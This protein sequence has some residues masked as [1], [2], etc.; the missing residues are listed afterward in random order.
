MSL[1]PPPPGSSS[2]A[3]AAVRGGSAG[4]IF[5]FFGLGRSFPLPELRLRGGG[6]ATVLQAT[7]CVVQSCV[8]SSFSISCFARSILSCKVSAT[9][10]STR[11]S[12]V[13]GLL[14]LGSAF[15]RV[16]LLLRG[17]LW[18][19]PWAGIGWLLGDVVRVTFSSWL[20]LGGGSGCKHSGLLLDNDLAID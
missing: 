1:L 5:F 9:P 16:C 18:I 20:V 3:G 2:P 13:V 7:S 10:A 11:L 12:A 15:F 6:A 17:G 14:H 19:G 4:P 8:L